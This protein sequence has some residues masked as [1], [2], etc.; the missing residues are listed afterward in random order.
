[1][2]RISANFTRQPLERQQT[3][4]GIEKNR[5]VIERRKKCL[6]FALIR[7]IRGQNRPCFQSTTPS[8]RNPDE[9]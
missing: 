9:P 6:S 1:M 4:P 5:I 7:V 2:T 3:W 8:T